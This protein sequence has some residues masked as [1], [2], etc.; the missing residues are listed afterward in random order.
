MGCIVVRKQN[1]NFRINSIIARRKNS[2]W[3][4][5]FILCSD[6]TNSVYLLFN[7]FK[8]KISGYLDRNNLSRIL[9][10]ELVIQDTFSCIVL[11]E[12]SHALYCAKLKSLLQLNIISPTFRLFTLGIWSWSISVYST[13][14]KNLLMTVVI[15]T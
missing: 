5:F 14:N 10:V 12:N 9:W 15:T 3:C 1:K 2:K 7:R 11:L 4:R 13:V 6:Y 8:W